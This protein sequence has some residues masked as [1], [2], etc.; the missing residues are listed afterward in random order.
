M[1]FLRKLYWQRMVIRKPTKPSTVI[2]TSPRVT[3]SHSN[4]DFILWNWPEEQI[5][6]FNGKNMLEMCFGKQDIHIHNTRL[7]SEWSVGLVYQCTYFSI[8]LIDVLVVGHFHQAMAEVV[9]GEDEKTGF[10]VAVDFLQILEK[11][12]KMETLK[13]T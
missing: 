6:K 7:I 9:V 10:Q 5:H 4:G 12:M 3:M 1:G 13:F 8:V 2:A 11:M